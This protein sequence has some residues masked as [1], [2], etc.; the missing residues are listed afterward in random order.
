MSMAFLAAYCFLLR[1]PSECLPIVHGFGDERDRQFQAAMFLAGGRL[2]LKLKR[3]KNRPLGSEMCSCCALV[4]GTFAGWLVASRYRKCWCKHDQA[5]CPV[6]VLGQFVTQFAPGSAIFGGLSPSQASGYLKACLQ[7]LNIAKADL[8][9]PHDLRRGHAED[10][11]AWG[12]ELAKILHWGEWKSPAF[13]SY[14]EASQLEADAVVSA[15][16]DESSE[17]EV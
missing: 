17:D 7:C 15:H 11:R 14:V 5:T 6:H 12:C 13:L 1:V 16:V 2:Q 3:R 8:Y 10:M 4:V 9:R